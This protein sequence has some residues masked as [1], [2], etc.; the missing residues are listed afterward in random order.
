MGDS[1]SLTSTSCANLLIICSLLQSV[2]LPV[3]Q[4]FTPNALKSF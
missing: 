2:L 4:L 3:V 1:A